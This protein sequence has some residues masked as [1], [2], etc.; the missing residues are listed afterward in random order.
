[1][2][3][4]HTKGISS[5]QEARARDSQILSDS[6]NLAKRSHAVEIHKSEERQRRERA[7]GGGGDTPANK[8]GDATTAGFRLLNVMKPMPRVGSCQ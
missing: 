3:A 5:E 2:N 8:D 1:M 6:K 7:G 4:S